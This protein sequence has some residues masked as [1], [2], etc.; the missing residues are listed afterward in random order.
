MVVETGK[1]E[2][3]AKKEKRLA[4]AAVKEITRDERIKKPQGAY[5]MWLNDNRARIAG[6]VGSNVKDLAKKAGDEWKDLAEDKKKPYEEKAEKALKDYE[7]FIASE[8]GSKLL[9]E[10]T[11]AM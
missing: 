5:F 11:G 2:K 4:K 1:R 6:E 7:T 9:N 8:E 3:K 10:Y